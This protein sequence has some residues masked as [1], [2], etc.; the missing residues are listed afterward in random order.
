MEPVTISPARTTIAAA[1]NPA[2][3]F[4]RRDITHQNGTTHADVRPRT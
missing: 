3:Y 4:S 1:P 2:T